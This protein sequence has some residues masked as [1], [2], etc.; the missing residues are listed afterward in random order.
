MNLILELELLEIECLN[1]LMLECG[2]DK[3]T[4]LIIH[5]DASELEGRG[6]YFYQLKTKDHQ[7][8]RK[9]VLTN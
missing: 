2:A 3:I 5:I 7:D 8:Y 9:M 1:V 4:L 6:I